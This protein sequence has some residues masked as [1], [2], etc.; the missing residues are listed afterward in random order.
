MAY[1]RR[2][3]P[4]KVIHHSD[5]GVQY[6]CEKYV[7]Y[8]KANKAKISCAG[9]G[10]PYENAFAESFMKT[11]KVEEVYLYNFITI[12]DVLERIPEFIEDVYNKKEFIHRLAT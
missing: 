6:L 4:T 5:R 11:L 8:L 10:N 7:Q 3:F 2:N 1:E 12:N 9:K